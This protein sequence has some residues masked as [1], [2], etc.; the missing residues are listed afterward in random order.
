LAVPK[1]LVSAQL[2]LNPFLQRERAINVAH[3]SG[4]NPEIYYVCRS[5]NNFCDT[6]IRENNL[7]E[8]DYAIEDDLVVK[9]RERAEL[10]PDV[11]PEFPSFNQVLQRHGCRD[12]SYP[13]H[14]RVPESLQEVFSECVK[15]Y[16]E[17]W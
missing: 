5:I 2:S 13:I 15:D 16:D 12:L 1:L 9:S 3:V 7:K 17:S 8:E 6:Y 10:D 4:V 11:V 14:N